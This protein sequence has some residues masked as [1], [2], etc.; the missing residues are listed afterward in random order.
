MVWVRV[1]SLNRRN[2]AKRMMQESLGDQ[3]RKL[4]QRPKGEQDLIKK[5]EGG[6][7]VAGTRRTS[8]NEADISRPV[9]RRGQPGQGETIGEEG[10]YGHWSLD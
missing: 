9:I 7:W 8:Q 10:R 5:P 3:T 6:R 4:Y 1:S 2:K